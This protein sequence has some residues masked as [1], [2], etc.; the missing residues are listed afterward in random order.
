MKVAYR[1]SAV[2][3][4]SRGAKSSRGS[5]STRGSRR[6]SNTT[7]TTVSLWEEK[8]TEVSLNTFN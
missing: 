6:S 7:L 4:L 3:S 5:R 2:T 1:L 8:F